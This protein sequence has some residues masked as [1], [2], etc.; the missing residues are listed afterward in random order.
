MNITIY[1]NSKSTA[2]RISD[3]LI[4]AG[5]IGFIEDNPTKNMVSVS[6]SISDTR[7]LSLLNDV[8]GIAKTSVE[9]DGGYKISPRMTEAI[10]LCPQKRFCNGFCNIDEIECNSILSSLGIIVSKDRFSKGG[11]FRIQ[12]REIASINAYLPDIVSDEDLKTI[13]ISR[14]S[15]ITAYINETIPV[16]ALCGRF[17]QDEVIKK[18][19]AL[20]ESLILKKWDPWSDNDEILK[21]WG[22]WSDNDDSEVEPINN[23]TNS[24]LD[25]AL[26]PNEMSSNI[27]QEEN[28]NHKPAVIDLSDESI[29]KL[30]AAIA[31]AIKQ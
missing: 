20:Q 2:N 18:I 28:V 3:A 13:S 30:A 23:T 12:S 16:S 9:I 19:E 26:K 21:K 15:L 7:M 24:L 31:D 29:R 4:T 6:G 25:Y 8:S 5:Q 10:L 27:G 11:D 1:F 14:D 22:P 17:K